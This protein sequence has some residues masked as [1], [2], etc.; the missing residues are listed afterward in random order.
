MKSGGRLTLVLLLSVAVHVLPWAL[1]RAAGQQASGGGGQ[2]A[3]TLA[4]VPESLGEIVDK[5]QEPVEV[6][7]Q[8]APPRTPPVMSP[9]PVSPR[10]LQSPGLAPMKPV[11]KAATLDAAPR[12]DKR[13][14]KPPKPKPATK[15]RVTPK[16]KAASAPRKAEKA[17]GGAQAAEQGNRGKAKIATGN[18]AREASLLRQ[19]GSVIRSRIERQKRR[20]P[21]VGKVRLR[22]AVYRS[23]KLASIGIIAS[24]GHKILDDAAVTAAKRARLPKAP[25]GVSQGPHTFSLSL[26]YER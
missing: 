17:S 3:I 15:L 21:G 13:P 12:L 1:W 19:W 7:H 25:P 4:A 16:P 23:G 10:A 8:M 20:A 26:R 9:S 6:Q 11:M 18:S 5:W 24:S 22:V 14:P 2:E